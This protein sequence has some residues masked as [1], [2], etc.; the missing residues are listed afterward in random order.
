MYDIQVFKYINNVISYH[1]NKFEQKEIMDNIIENK[2]TVNLY[3]HCIQLKF[4]TKSQ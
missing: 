3:I 4:D 1:Y 2:I